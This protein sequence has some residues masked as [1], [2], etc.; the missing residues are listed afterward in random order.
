M[1]YYCAMNLRTLPRIYVFSFIGLFVLLMAVLFLQKEEPK[2]I[3]TILRA[4]INGVSMEPTL[5]DGQMVTYDTS[6]RPKQGDIVVFSCYT[7]K[8]K[9]MKPS[10]NYLGYTLIKRVYAMH[11]NCYDVRGDNTESSDDSRWLGELCGDQIK[12]HGVVTKY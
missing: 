4:S 12:I 10:K 1:N 8:C 11:D 2:P 5:K 7:E 6:L 9:S 3:Q